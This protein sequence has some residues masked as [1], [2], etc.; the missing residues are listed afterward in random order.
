MA[1]YGWLD[2]YLLAKPGAQKDFKAEWEWWRYQV[3]SKLFAA[4]MRPGAEH[5]R[6]YAERDLI[7]LKC[8]PEWSLELR[9]DHP[10][11]LP[12]FYSN[13]KLWI[14]VVLDG[15]VDDDLIRKL[16]DHSYDL[17]FSKLTK[18]LQREILEASAR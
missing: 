6:Q 18:K 4:T 12:G 1:D 16:C 15:S 3:G 13:K 17:V 11:I 10:S 14:S 8:D 9:A 5:D 7:T 2:E